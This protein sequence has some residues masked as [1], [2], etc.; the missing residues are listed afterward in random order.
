MQKLFS[1]GC[2]LVILACNTASALA[3]HLI[4]QQDLPLFLTSQQQDLPLFLTSQQ[5]P[6]LSSSL[7]PLKNVLGVIRPTVEIIDHLT[8]T[9][10]VG[11]LGTPATIASQAY[12]KE[13]AKLFP[14]ISVTTHACPLWV[15]LV[16][17]NQTHSPQALQI[18]QSDIQQLL[19]LDPQIDAVILGCT[20]Y[21]LLLPQIRQFV[22][23]NINLLSQNDFL[24]SSLKNYLTHHQ[25]IT[26]QLT[27]TTTR[28]FLTTGDSHNF[29]L[30]A[31]QFLHQP[32]KSQNI[33]LEN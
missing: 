10:H 7:Q 26:S 27:T 19:N 28:N 5:K 29:D 32:I 13:I 33:Q 21:P 2:P 15:N 18:I 6:S 24:A 16:E 23:E 14:H 8:H 4:Q 17:N 11:I 30:I 25:E 12:P 9:H 1:F 22:P 31:T 20:H 3:L